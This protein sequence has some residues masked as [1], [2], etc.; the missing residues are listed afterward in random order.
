MMKATPRMLFAVEPTKTS[1]EKSCK[2]LYIVWVGFVKL[3]EEDIWM[4]HGPT[5]S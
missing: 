2:A 3:V 1:I 4:R 5:K